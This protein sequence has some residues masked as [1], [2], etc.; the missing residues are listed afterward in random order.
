[1]LQKIYLRTIMWM[2]DQTGRILVALK[3][4]SRAVK[5]LCRNTL[6]TEL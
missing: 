1:M 3:F 4:H 5:S 6:S 2:Y